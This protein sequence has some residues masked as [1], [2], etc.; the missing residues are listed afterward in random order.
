MKYLYVLVSDDSDYYLENAMLSISSLRMHTPQAFVSLLMDSGTEKTLT[1]KRRAIVDLVDEI[2]VPAIE[3]NW[4]KRER[5][6]WL[7]TSARAHIA[8]DFLYIDCDTVIA[9]DLSLVSGLD[10]ELGAVMDAHTTWDEDISGA[11]RKLRDQ[12]RK[13]DKALG[14]ES[15]LK[16]NRCFN[17]G[18]ILCRDTLNTHRFFAKWHELWQYS[19]LISPMDQTPLNQTDYLFQGF[20]REMDGVWNCQ[21]YAPGMLQYLS[22]ARI[23]HFWGGGVRESETFYRLASPSFFAQIKESGHINAE[24]RDLLRFPRAAFY[25]KTYLA[26]EVPFLYSPTFVFL[27]KLYKLRLIRWLDAPLGLLLDLYVRARATRGGGVRM[28]RWRLS[29]KMLLLSKSVRRV[30]C[31]G[32]TG[33][34]CIHP[35]REF[36]K[37]YRRNAVRI[38]ARKARP[39]V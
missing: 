30:G 4:T 27:K 8:G 23:I 2:L 36:S 37:H 28:G 10:M 32:G 7:K 1:G 33:A 14:F 34:Y 29:R 31:Q 15:S 20:I 39:Y 22:S 35:R 18:V 19:H 25:E 5:S 38:R 17:S 16:T 11:L 26:K 3:G 12:Y 9:G 6:R 24:L 13:W 21:V